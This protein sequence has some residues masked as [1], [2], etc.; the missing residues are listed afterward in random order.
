[1][2]GIDSSLTPEQYASLIIES[3]Q[4][5]KTAEACDELIVST[6]KLKD[7]YQFLGKPIHVVNNY[8]VHENFK[9]NVEKQ[10]DF[11]Y[12]SPSL[13]I[14]PELDLIVSAFKSLPLKVGGCWKFLIMG[15]EF[16]YKYLSSM[17]IKNINF[18]LLPYAEYSVYIGKLSLAKYVLIP[19]SDTNFNQ[20]KTAIRA[21]DSLLAGALPIVSNIGNNTLFLKNNSTSR[22]VVDNSK[23]GKLNMSLPTNEGD[24][25]ELLNIAQQYTKENFG[26]SAAKQ[27]IKSV[28][29]S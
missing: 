28:F 4:F 22:L 2:S 7:S 17:S 23:W 9:R 6:Q 19:I 18:T 8:L 14:Q 26:H 27:K 11:A 15:N 21:Y 10:F 3:E 20:C 29:S 1:M 5:M 25:D 16:A 12:T 24:Y 13:S